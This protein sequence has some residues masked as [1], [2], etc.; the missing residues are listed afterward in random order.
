MYRC[1]D[2]QPG[3]YKR[4]F[5]LFF[6]RKIYTSF[7]PYTL[8][9]FTLFGGNESIASPSDSTAKFII[10]KIVI[11]G[12]KRTKERIITRELIFHP[13]DTLD[14]TELDI[15]LGKSTENLNN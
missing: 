2:V 11:L 10:K 8:F 13:G 12:N 7:I 1:V 5:S 9:L 4:S 14:A 15:R 6:L 3:R